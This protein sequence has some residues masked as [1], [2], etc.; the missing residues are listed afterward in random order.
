MSTITVH[1]PHCDDPHRCYEDGGE[2]QCRT[3]GT[4]I[5]P[6]TKEGLINS[7]YIFKDVLGEYRCMVRLK[8]MEYLSEVN[9]ILYYKMPELNSGSYCEKFNVLWC[10]Y[11]NREKD[12]CTYVK[13]T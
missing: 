1:C 13:T 2:F 10:K 6:K 11:Y 12:T 8:P 4:T 3:C 7:S 9:C 5:V